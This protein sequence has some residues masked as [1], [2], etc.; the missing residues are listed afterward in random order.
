VFFDVTPYCL[1]L[2]MM[3]LLFLVRRYMQDGANLEQ[4]RSENLK[5]LQ[6]LETDCYL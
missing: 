4:P 5:F 2:G 1:T 3:T 6:E